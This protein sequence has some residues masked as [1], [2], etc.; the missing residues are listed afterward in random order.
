MPEMN[1]LPRASA[2]TPQGKVS[3]IWAPEMSDPSR[4][5]RSSTSAE[6]TAEKI[7]APMVTG[8]VGSSTSSTTTS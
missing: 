6:L 1:E 4:G 7:V 8:A 2:A 5:L 3:K